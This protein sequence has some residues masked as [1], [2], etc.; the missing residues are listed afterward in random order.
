MDRATG[1][2]LLNPERER[3]KGD[4]LTDIRQ[5]HVRFY[6]DRTDDQRCFDDHDL[7]ERVFLPQRC[8][9]NSEGYRTPRRDCPK[10]PCCDGPYERGFAWRLPALNQLPIPGYAPHAG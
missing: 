8:L 2:N 10:R 7:G 1:M 6:T 9:L 5:A 4:K 3:E